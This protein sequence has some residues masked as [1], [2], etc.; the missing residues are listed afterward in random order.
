[1]AQQDRIS[2]LVALEGADA[3]LKQAIASARQSLSQFG[4]SAKQ[5]GETASRSMESVA[6]IVTDLRGKLLGLVAAYASFS[7]VRGVAEM[8]EQWQA[9]SAR[10]KLAT[11]GQQEFERAL[12]GT[13]AIAQRMGASLDSVATVYGKM[14]QATRGLGLEQS[15]ALQLT[16]SVSQALRI[17]GASA[18]ESSA[19]LLQ[20]GQAMASGVLRGDEFNSVME[21]APR[22][23][24]ALADGL[25]VSIGKLRQMAEA[26]QLTADVVSKALL[27]QSAVLKAEY[28][29]M[30]QTIGQ[31]FTRIGN[32]A[33]AFFGQI[34]DATGAT[35]TLARA[36]T[37]VADHFDLFAKAAGV[38]ASGALLLMAQRTIPALIAALQALAL[39][40]S[41][42]ALAVGSRLV[43]AFQALTLPLEFATVALGRF[44]VALA[45]L[46]AGVAGFQLG[47]YLREQFDGVRRVGD[48]IGASLGAADDAVRA[49][50]SSVARLGSGDVR[51]AAQ[52]LAQDATRIASAWS[53]TIAAS[54]AAGLSMQQMSKTAGASLQ[55]LQ[56]RISAVRLGL[57][58]SATKGMAALDEAAGKLQSTLQKLDADITKASGSVKAALD[59]MAAVRAQQTAAIDAAMAQRDAEMQRAATALQTS[60]Q[61]RDAAL[62]DQ[63]AQTNALLTGADWLAAQADPQARFV[64]SSFAADG[65]GRYWLTGTLTAKG[66]SQPLRLLVTS[67]P[68]GADLVLD[69]S[70]TLNRTVFGLGTGSWA[71]TSVVA[72]AIPVQVHLVLSP[73]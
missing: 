64:S 6:Q 1:M 69:T 20:F 73:Q 40:A 51:G 2:I 15:Q 4:A 12:V 27:S 45:A 70:F 30:P 31:A 17:S 68:A 11:T 62:R 48:V 72:A 8:A 38:V 23:A 42:S 55:E 39:Q 54:R 34:N 60:L 22:L 29:Q 19:A 43:V 25:G 71:D 33:T 35:S 26:G 3:S 56:A 50:F 49:V 14:Q 37:F 57:E 21:N 32:A 7:G 63:I 13:Q 61:A 53:D 16:E 66:H 28:A 52:G 9:L 24:R 67:H 47:S 5:T 36:L 41:A 65:P 59:G 58:E 10:L 46:G 18:S 44:N